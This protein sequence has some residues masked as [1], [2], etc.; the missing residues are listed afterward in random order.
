MSHS[1]SYT[2]SYHINISF[3][4]INDLKGNDTLNERTIE[5][6]IISLIVIGNALEEKNASK[7]RTERRPEKEHNGK[8]IMGI[9]LIVILDFLRVHLVERVQRKLNVN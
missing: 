3:L 7:K 6:F 5:I 4:E 2:Y 8:N 1:A 9:I